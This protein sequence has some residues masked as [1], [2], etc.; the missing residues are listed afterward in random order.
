MQSVFFNITLGIEFFLLTGYLFYMLFRK[1]ADEED[2]DAMLRW[3]LRIIG[4]LTVGLIVSVA[5]VATRMPALDLALATILLAL[6]VMALTV[7]Y[8]DMGRIN[9]DSL[10]VEET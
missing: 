5:L 6:D 10:L 1:Y 8:M 4:A 9:Q 2:R 3:M 7:A